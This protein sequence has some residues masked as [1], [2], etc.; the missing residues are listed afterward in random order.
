MAVENPYISRVGPQELV[1]QQVATFKERTARN[2]PGTTY[3]IFY[4]HEQNELLAA[5]IE[6]VLSSKFS[7]A[8]DYGTGVFEGT[9][10]MVNERTGI[11]HVILLSA[12]S[13][14]MFNRS[15][16]SRGYQA[17]VDRATF[18]Q[19]LLDFVAVNGPDLFKNPKGGDKPVRAYIRPTIHPAPLGGYGVSLSQG[20]PIDAAIL[21]WPWP[22]Y[23]R[24]EIYSEGGVAAVN[25]KQ[26]LFEIRGKHASNYG[27]SAK[28]GQE[29]RKQG[30]DELIYLAPYLVDENGFIFWDDPQDEDKKLRF[31]SLS[32]GPGE[33][34][35]AITRD[36][37]KLVYA[38]MRVNRLGG[39]V[40]NYTVNYLVP[41][42]GLEAEEGDITLADLRNGKY[43][44]AGM[45]G[46]AVKIAPI[47]QINLY[48]CAK[49][50]EEIILFNQGD[51]PEMMQRLINRWNLET[52]GLVDPSH[53]SLLTPVDMEVGK[54][55][56]EQLDTLFKS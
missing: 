56:R 4:S 11:P 53:P 44:A 34:I 54:R 12:R 28:D 23:L 16:P 24:P 18:D 19:A 2:F 40:L 22:D 48:R 13:E 52:R 3:A 43:V 47:R 31:G 50:V 8:L 14:R 26:R 38:P 6:L 1:E 5:P 9:S 20:Y 10:A 30:N 49:L 42:L 51:L 25:G 32:D 45:I 46:N 7:H 35:F 36:K 21:T 37:R 33:E 39:T 55:I 15:L 29:V 17:P 41:R 27:A